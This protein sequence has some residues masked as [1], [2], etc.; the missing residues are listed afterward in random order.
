MSFCPSDGLT[1]LQPARFRRRVNRFLV[2]CEQGDRT[3]LAHLPNPGRLLEL[4][5]PD[6]TVYLRPLSDPERRTR[7]V[8]LAVERA[9]RPIFLHTGLTN[10]VAAF[11]IEQDALPPLQGYRV[12]RREVPL[13]GHR[14]DLLLDRHGHPLLLE[15]KSCTLFGRHLALFPDAVTR[16]GRQHLLHLAGQVRQGLTTGVLFLVHTD[17]VTSFL[18]DYHTDF[19]FAQTLYALRQRL[20]I[21]VHAVGWNSRL[22]LTGP[23]HTVSLPWSILE[24]EM[25]DRGVYLLLLELDRPQHLEIG[26]LGKVSFP[27]GHYVYIGSARR[28]LSARIARHLRRRKTLFWHIDYLRPHADR[29]QALPIRTPDDLE[30]ALAVDLRSLAD[31]LIPGFGSSDCDCPSHL[32]YFATPPLHRPDFIERLLYWRIYRLEERL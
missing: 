8:V 4:L 5:L 22:A 13:G 17:Q 10:D 18:P 32:L 30:C 25:D 7:H 27:A 9:G 24:Q 2:E 11:L 6:R 12:L 28:H 15:V 19:A 16:R 3:I 21:L 26:R 23:G 31:D 20:N 1:D 29:V 14:Y